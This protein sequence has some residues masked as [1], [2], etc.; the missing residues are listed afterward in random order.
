MAAEANFR[1]M[2][3]S[4]NLRNYFK[5]YEGGPLPISDDEPNE[6]IY[7]GVGHPYSLKLS[8]SD[9]KGMY[10]SINRFADT[11]SDPL[12]MDS[13]ME[14]D[15]QMDE[16]KY[17][18]T[19]RISCD[20]GLDRICPPYQRCVQMVADTSSGFCDCIDTYFRN[21]RGD[22]VKTPLSLDELVSND[23]VQSNQVP[24]AAMSRLLAA[25]T[26][27]APTISSVDKKLTVS[28]VSKDVRLPEKE[29]TLAAYTVSDGISGNATTYK[30]MWSLISQPGGDVNGTMSDQTKD[31][32]K[33][34][35]LSE[36][37][38]RFKV[39]VT[40]TNNISGEAFANVT[41][42]PQKR[43][44]QAPNVVITPDHVTVKLPTSQTILDGGTSTVI[45]FFNTFFDQ[46]Y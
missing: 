45:L 12:Y 16:S 32:I 37:L 4:Q 23:D 34:T 25:T 6:P 29:V 17:Y 33:L 40:G 21:N 19:S 3:P 41:V 11:I 13:G 28:V 22:C 39:V 44:N 26:T 18:E 9:L 14:G 43:I 31:T 1:S 7:G 24:I 8:A 38:Y 20:I 36:G 2:L 27:I 10:P 30:Y 35:N 5:N 15:Q 46:V 42:L